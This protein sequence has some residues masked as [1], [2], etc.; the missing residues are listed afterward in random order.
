MADD[1]IMNPENSLATRPKGIIAR[2]SLL[3]LRHEWVLT[4]CM[5]L[6]M[7]AVLAP[8]LI[9]LGLKHGTIETMRD[10]LIEDP[11]NREIRPSRT[12]QLSPQWFAEMR[13]RPETGFIIPTILRGSSI[14]RISSPDTG[15]RLTIDLVPTDAGD[16][17]ILENGG[18]IPGEGECVLTYPAAEQL[19]IKQGAVLKAKVTRTRGGKR[20]FEEVELRVTAVL[21]ARADALARMY[22][23][24]RFVSDVEAYR[25]GLAV[26][27]RKWPGGTP[28]PFLSYDGLWV[29]MPQKLSALDE[30]RVIIN[31]G[32][33]ELHTL[34]AEEFRKD[35][36]FPVPEEYT[37]Y[38]LRSRGNPIQAGS[39]KSVK[40]K[41]RGR[42]A[43][44]LPFTD[45]LEIVTDAG[46]PIKLIGISLSA[47]KSK[48][49][50][51]PELP[52]GKFDAHADLDKKRSLLLPPAHQPVPA[53]LTV[54][55]QENDKIH[56][57]VEVQSG[58]FGD[59]AIVPAE[60]T[61]VLRTG[62]LRK[63]LY[64]KARGGFLLAKAGY[65]GFRLYARGID[66]VPALY[67]SFI[68]Q[69]IEVLTRV[70][71]I[72]KVKVLDRGLTRIFWLVAIVGIVGGMASLVASLYAAV[73]RK[74]RDISVL[75]LMGL[76]RIEVFLF[77]IYQ[78]LAMAVMSVAMAI[79][80]Y[81][82]LASIINF[83]F[84]ADLKL[85]QKICTLPY[86]YFLMTFFITAAIAALSSLLAAWKAT[87]IDPAEAI[88]EE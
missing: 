61:G 16:P 30:R 19:G 41:L 51:L 55:I 6:A 7:A 43:V 81:A 39:I 80:G 54:T 88:R 78:G 18:A 58:G 14:V 2:L 31:T 33:A 65:R 45:K 67:R 68:D 40:N 10:R 52:W 56:F 34:S 66:D 60:L 84:S 49:L 3:D 79:G 59:Y 42:G 21:G 4:L 11:V 8:L 28:R 32:L 57:P 20:Q 12:L 64:D 87:E 9:L 25:E 70:R 35:M 29:L 17:L 24:S 26:P 44:L 1:K 5:I 82:L 86:A 15:K 22:T 77:P 73:E 75:R 37:I 71:E 48:A 85:G 76:S 72:E 62:M 63:I 74:K 47:S 38:R 36:G 50:G 69:E 27:E 53:A 83:V 13:K 23:R 46:K